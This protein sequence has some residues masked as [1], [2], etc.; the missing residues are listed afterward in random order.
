MIMKDVDLGKLQVDRSTTFSL[1]ARV[2]RRL[3]WWHVAL[4]VAVIGFGYSA[5]FSGTSEVQ[6]TPVVVSYPSQQYVVLNSTG[7][8]VARRKAAVASKGTGR[9]EWLDVAEGSVVKEGT[10][11]AR[12]ESRDVEASLSNAEAN[13]AVAAAAIES[14][15]AEE[16]DA[17][18]NLARMKN[19]Y[20]KHYISQIMYDD[21]ISRATRAR[22]A[23]A[24]TKASWQAAKANEDYARNAVEYTHIRAPFDGVVISKSANVGDIVTPMSSAADSKGAVVVM[25]DMS[26][27]EVDA[28]VS[29]SSV[30]SLKVGQ[31]CEIVLDAFP[32]KRFRGEVSAIV[33]TVNRSSATVTTKVRFID[34]S[35]GILPDMS[36]RVGFLSRPIANADEKPVLAANAD[37]VTSRDGH[38]LVFRRSNG[39]RVTAV[40]VVVGPMLGDVRQITGPLHAGDVLVMKPP[41]RLRDGF[42]IKVAEDR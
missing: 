29:E 11:I 25:A 34:P 36:A 1:Q 4:G 38:D 33:P 17:Q 22:A 19:L 5:I 15:R 24:S 35:P 9:L 10:I 39:D 41:R 40:P 31:P 13:T 6:T 28:D 12:L 3:R 16:S 2:R 7:Y 26:T 18:M 42:S 23:I 14:S 32:E 27:L 20:A 8:V 21:A 30:A 37:A